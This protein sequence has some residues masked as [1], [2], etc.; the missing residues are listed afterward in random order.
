MVF[1][2]HLGAGVC[3][4]RIESNTTQQ[5]RPQRL[6]LHFDAGGAEFQREAR[7]VPEAGLVVHI[8]VIGRADEGMNGYAVDHIADVPSEHRSYVKTAEEYRRPKRDRTQVAGLQFKRMSRNIDLE[9]RRI[10]APDEFPL[11]LAGGL[12]GKQADI[13]PGGEGAQPL[14]IASEQSRLDDPEDCRAGQQRLGLPRGLDLHQHVRVIGRQFQVLYRSEHDLLE[15]E[16]RLA[17]L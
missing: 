5:E 7:S 13:R 6:E 8:A 17:R 3:R 14:E 12:A 11:R 9:N 4:W 15:L 1:S 2:A 10:L 16:L